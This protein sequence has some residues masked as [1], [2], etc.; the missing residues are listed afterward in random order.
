MI[1]RLFGE[2]RLWREKWSYKG[3]FR[4]AETEEYNLQKINNLL[5]PWVEHRLTTNIEAIVTPKFFYGLSEELGALRVVYNGITKTK[6]NYIVLHLH[7]VKAKIT[8]DPYLK[9]GLVAVFTENKKT[10]DSNP[11]VPSQ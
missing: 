5:S 2:D 3:M 10:I 11:K 6:E 1:D 8:F 4:L 9:D 7:N